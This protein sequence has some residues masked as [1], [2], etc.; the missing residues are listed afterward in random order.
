MINH[1]TPVSLKAPAGCDAPATLAPKRLRPSERSLKIQAHNLE[2][3]AV[4]Y[5]RQSTRQQVLEHRES[6]ERQYALADHAATLGWPTDRVVVIDEDQAHT[7]STAEGRQGFHRLLAEVSLD[8]VGIVL[9]IE[10]SRMARSCRDW[11]N[12]F[13]VCGIFGTLLADHDGVYDANDPNDR[14][15]L[16]LKGIMSEMELFT[17]RNRLMLG[18]LNKA[19]RG[20]LFVHMPIGYVRTP[21]GSVEF[22]PDEQVQ[23][24]VRL[25]FEKFEELGSVGAVFRYL[26]CNNIR[27]GVRPHSGA[28][29]GQLEWR[30]PCL[31]SMFNMLHRPIY[32]G[33][34]AHGRST[35]DPKRRVPGRPGSGRKLTKMEDW[36][37]LIRGRLPAY[38]TWEKYLENQRRLSQNQTRA[39]APGVPRCGMALLAGLAYCGNCNCRMSVQYGA[40]TKPRYT[41]LRHIWR[42]TASTCKGL[43]AREIDNLVSQQVLRALE[44]AAL[45]LSLRAG[46]DIQRD[47][48]RIAQHWKR[49]VEQARYETQRVE[50]QYQLAEPENRLVAR[51]LEARW[52]EALR[53][54][55]QV[56]EE[57]ERF[58]QHSTPDFTDEARAVITALAK[59]IPALWQAPTTTDADRKE[60]IRHLVERVVATVQND[61]ERVDV[62]IHWA[63]GFVS[64]H[65]IVRPVKRYQQLQS[66]N[67]L[68]DRVAELRTAG[69][70]AAQIAAQLNRE[71][72]R[73]PRRRITF[74]K[75]IVQKLL[76]RRGLSSEKGKPDVLAADE[77]WLSDLAR[78]LKIPNATV[79]DWVRYGWVH[80]RRSP[81]Q[82]FWIAW[83]D[84]EELDRLRRL[85]ASPQAKPCDQYPP[86]LTT[87]KH[88]PK[89]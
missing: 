19:Q 76:S 64:Q 68:M 81:I 38:I 85:R 50:R 52:E 22:D 67:H 80:A 86:E 13:E 74:H 16:G 40:S 21:T 89:A 69:H 57:H 77:W 75:V 14:L 3:L 58:L 17:M 61:T 41:C 12:L 83:A 71:G 32:A 84:A 51:T 72:F 47:R 78:E 24:V 46:D 35:V 9:G 56:E 27:V 29:R 10:I 23:A 82:H 54:Q 59:D 26:V 87:P 73:P 88:R 60:I 48:D 6:R 4:V 49:R 65:E 62:T 70:T 7:G 53:N 28:N 66:F 11:H 39:Q 31:A 30:R 63:G 1:D 5:V 43:M 18:A 2:R 20:E 34:Y 25:I 33:A 15:L 8:H 44:P 45:E 36:K 55:R 42:G 37:V 79:R